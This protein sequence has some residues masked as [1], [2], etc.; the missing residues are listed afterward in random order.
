MEVMVVMDKVDTEDMAD[1][2]VVMEVVLMITTEETADIMTTAVITM[3]NT[4][5]SI[6]TITHKRVIIISKTNNSKNFY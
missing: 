1:T 6:P 3:V 5:L 2:T 4:P